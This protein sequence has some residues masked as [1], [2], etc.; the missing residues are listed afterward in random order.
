MTASDAHR[1]ALELSWAL[2]AVEGRENF[3]AAALE[4]VREMIPAESVGRYQLDLPAGRA[5]LHSH[6]PEHTDAPFVEAFTG[7]IATHPTLTSYTE[8][9]TDLSPR[10]VSDVASEQVWRSTPIFSELYIPMGV[11]HNVTFLTKPLGSGLVAG[12]SL[13]RRS[14]DFTDSEVDLCAAVQPVLA[15]LDMVHDGQSLAEGVGPAEAVEAA[16][17]KAGLTPRELDILSLLAGGLTA[18]QI[19]RV[20]RIS[21]LTVRK[22]LERVYA[23][24]GTHDRLL[25]VDRARTIGLI[26]PIGAVPHQ[27]PAQGGS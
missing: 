4:L 18:V 11:R 1:S 12:W 17:Q 14:G 16:R 9:P 27:R 26:R 15:A 23:K 22:H 8:N 24:L 7:Y 20:R 25:A 21:P 6:P 19:G 3:I 2:S 5:V 13:C 10:R